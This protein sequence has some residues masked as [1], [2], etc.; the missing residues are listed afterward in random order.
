[1]ASTYSSRLRTELIGSGEQANSWGTTTNNNLS[2]IF[3]EAISGVYEKSLNGLT[4]SYTLTTAQGPVTQANNEVRQAAIRFH[5]F[6]TAFLINQ[7]EVS[8]AQYDRVYIV[9]NDGTDNGTIQF[10]L[11]TGGATS[12]I[13]P[14]GGRAIIATN[15]STWYTISSSG[16]TLWRTITAATDNI[17]G[18]EKLFVDTSSNAI[19][20]TLPS[21]PATG[22]EISFLDIAD[23]FDTNALSI[24]PNGKKVFGATANGTVST[25]GAGFKLVYTGNTYGWRITEK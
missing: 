5:S 12:D 4:N 21:A 3:D 1:M 23:N 15:G 8:A 22:D 25:E 13:I 11:G 20:L 14:P 6:T 10:R 24:N 17:F 16:S 19:T 2:R 7:P 18:G 9:I